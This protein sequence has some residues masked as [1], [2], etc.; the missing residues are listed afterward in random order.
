MNQTT[1]PI[2]PVA[3]HASA[4]SIE[5]ASRDAVERLELSRARMRLAL[6]GTDSARGAGTSGQGFGPSTQQPAV[7]W[8]GRLAS[9]P[10]VRLLLDALAGRWRRHPWQAS[11]LLANDLARTVLQPVA[12]SHPW[13]LVAVSAAVGGSLIYTR[14][15][16]WLPRPALLL[17]LVPQLLA[18]ALKSPDVRGWLA[19]RWHAQTP[20]GS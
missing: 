1:K 8:F 12:Q 10:V 7:G 20:A 2:P 14:A 18:Q 15:W 16:R 3:D 19:G 13:R 6:Q 5:A 4:E 17:G 9:M 11:A